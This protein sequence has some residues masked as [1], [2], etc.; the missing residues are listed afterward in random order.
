MSTTLN[1]SRNA[2]AADSAGEVTDIEGTP[3]SSD[4]SGPIRL[5][6]WV[7][8]VGFGGFL[9]WAALAPLDEGVSAPAT[10]SIETHRRIIQHM[11]GGVVKKVL[12]K[13]GEQVKAGQSLLEIDEAQT[14]ANFESVRQNYLAQRAAESRLLA[15]Q[16]ERATIEFHPDLLAGAGDPFVKQHMT[17]QTRLFE[18]RR[19]ALQAELG[20]ARESIAGSEAQIAGLTSMLASRTKQAALQDE[21]IGSIQELSSQGYAPRNQVL[22]LQQS[23]AELRSTMSDLDANRTR[24]RQSI[25][26]ARMRMVQRAQEYQK[27]A[28]AQL[29]EVRREVQAGQEKL[30]AMTEELGRVQIKSPVDGQ[31]VGM[32]ITAI[33]GVVSPGQKLMEVVPVGETLLIDAKIPTHVIDRIKVG[34]S[35]DIRFSS[36]AHSP[37]L[38][39]DAK[40]VSLASDTITEGQGP[41]TQTYYLG[42]IQLTPKGVK[43]L[44]NRVM[45]PGMPAEVV[46]KTGERTMLTYLMHPLT[47]RVAQAMKEE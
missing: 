25:A 19:G 47:K 26:E 42:R 29:A 20:A 32:T 41:T 3:L 16:T 30:R 5:G 40:L 36:F 28:G 38:V 22:Q 9:L 17:G 1:R 6:F 18:A 21:Q 14:K 15:E 2:S 46:I 43:T 33:G 23:Q 8:I 11:S 35:T 12:A 44:G 4:T 31:V 27:E 10:V 13:E 39:L 34:D 37:Q 24:A 7:L 45:Q